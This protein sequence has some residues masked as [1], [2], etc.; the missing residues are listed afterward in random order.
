MQNHPLMLMVKHKHKHLLKHP[1]CIGLLRHKWKRFG[2]FVFYF[3]FLLYILFLTSVTTNVLLK[4]EHRNMTGDGTYAD[5]AQE[6]TIKTAENISKW[7]VIILATTLL[8]IELAE[9]IR[10]RIFKKKI[11]LKND[12]ISDEV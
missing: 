11:L 7:A 8:F 9:I 6:T 4:M 2:R 12:D 3:Q 1:L 5:H 10:V